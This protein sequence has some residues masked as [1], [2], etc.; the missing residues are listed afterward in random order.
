MRVTVRLRFASS[1]RSCVNSGEDSALPTV[2]SLSS[3]SHE[4]EGTVSLSPDS[5]GKMICRKILFTLVSRSRRRYPTSLSTWKTSG[6]AKHVVSVA[7]QCL[8]LLCEGCLRP[9]GKTPQLAECQWL[10]ALASTT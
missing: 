3:A 10:I 5:S 7:P 4:Y 6:V 9:K 8:L 2:S 1:S